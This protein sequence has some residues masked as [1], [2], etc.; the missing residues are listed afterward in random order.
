[1][2]SETE[3]QGTHVTLLPGKSELRRRVEEIVSATPVVDI[4]THLL[5]RQF[6]KMNLT[7][8]DE[9][10]TYHYLIAEVFRSSKVNTEVF[11][12]MSKS[13]QADLI[14]RSLFVENSPVSEA[15]RGIVTILSEL[16]LNP[17]A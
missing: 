5:A 15:T 12:R 8:I 9:L 6:G 14:W 7:G 11:W 17:N 13:E 1:M 10:L 2:I 16:G 4:H 3:Y